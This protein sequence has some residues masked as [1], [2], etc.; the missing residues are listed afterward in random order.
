[1]RR[2]RAA[3]ALLVGLACCALATAQG[4]GGAPGSALDPERLRWSR[5]DYRASKFFVTLTAEVEIEVVERAAARAALVEPPAGE[6][7]QPSADLLR[8]GIDSRL[9][10]RENRIDLWLEPRTGASLQRRELQRA[11]RLDRNRVRTY[12]YAAAGVHRFTRRPVNADELERPPAE[13]SDADDSYD[14]FTLVSEPRL[15]ITEPSA[16]F[17]VLSTAGLG[18]RGDALD[19]PVYSKGRLF[20][21]E[22]LVTS[23][24]RIAADYVVERG[25]AESRVSGDVDALELTL[26]SR[27]VRRGEEAPELELL[28]LRGDVTVFLD[29]ELRVPIELRGDLRWA[30]RGR[31]RLERVVLDEDPAERGDDHGP[32]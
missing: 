7:L 10:G 29:P 30:G 14:G 13:W 4:E 19:V 3:P 16:L 27:A 28:G 26:R 12:R 17:Y 22:V 21:V 20:S 6:G 18:A 24:T 15:P 1:M 2:R 9:L 25:G 5:L 31:I 8:L 32:G 11:G 23:R